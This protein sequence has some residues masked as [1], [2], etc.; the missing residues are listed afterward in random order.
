MIYS[1]DDLDWV[2][3]LPSS[4]TPRPCF[5]ILSSFFLID[6]SVLRA[7]VTVASPVLCARVTGAHVP[8]THVTRDTRHTQQKKAQ[9]KVVSGG[10]W[11]KNITTA[12]LFNIISQTCDLTSFPE[13]L[14]LFLRACHRAIS[15]ELLLN[16]VY[17]LPHI[18]VVTHWIFLSALHH[19]VSEIRS[20]MRLEDPPLYSNELWF[21]DV[22]VF[23]FPLL[24]SDSRRTLTAISIFDIYSYFW[25]LL[26]ISISYSDF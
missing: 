19:F 24:S 4:H 22:Y 9:E 17:R 16:R 21:E 5:V 20:F 23:L 1:F 2:D 25:H 18:R 15:S 3:S 10:G 12:S 26:V 14:S 6:V 7:S 11:K 8:H 13:F